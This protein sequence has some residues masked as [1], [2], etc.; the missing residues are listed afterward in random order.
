VLPPDITW[1]NLT[2]SYGHVHPDGRSHPA[3]DDASVARL[4]ATGLDPAGNRLDR[5]MPTY[6]V[7][8]QDMADLLAYM[9]VLEQE[10]DPGLTDTSLTLGTLLPLEGPQGALGQ[11]MRA[12]LQ[13]LFADVNARGG[14]FGRRLELQV[15]PAGG[16]P[17]ETLDRVRQAL[18]EGQIFALVGAYT[19]GI[20]DPLGEMAEQLRVPVIGPFTQSPRDP[21]AINNHTF[22]IYSGLAEQARAL[23]RHAR[24]SIVRGAA[25]GV[26]VVTTEGAGDL[27][28][29]ALQEGLHTPSGQDPT[30]AVIR[31]PGGAADLPA[32]VA[33]V[34]EARPQ[35][36]FYLGGPAELQGLLRGLADGEAVPSVLVP[37]LLVSGALTDLPAAYDGKVFVS[38]PTVPADVSPEGRQAYGSLAQ[39]HGLPQAHLAAQV[40]AYA[41]VQVLLEGLK[42]AGRDLSRAVL[43]RQVERL[44][45]F[46]TGVTPP[47]RYGP[48]RRVGAAGAHLTVLDLQARQLRPVGEWIHAE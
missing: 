13:A 30:P 47:L 8:D 46:R 16:S 35:A 24:Q 41:A 26:A 43:V 33:R 48:N 42:Q 15:I 11:A 18:G 28:V 34:R 3:F 22:Y 17:R 6:E 20:D 37:A 32:L 14:V 40:A 31:Y 2:K 5:S 19:A 45:D 12:V 36:L 29:R 38:Y 44:Y 25:A 1:S 9:K 21:S 4:I 10:R 27:A 39:R 23:A 7:A